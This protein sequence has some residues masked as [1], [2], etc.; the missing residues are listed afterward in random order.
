MTTRSPDDITEAAGLTL[1]GI[2]VTVAVLIG[3]V[4]W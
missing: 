4:T 2:V 1:L 3:A